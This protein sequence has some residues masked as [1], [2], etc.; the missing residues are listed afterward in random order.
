MERSRDDPKEYKVHLIAPV[1]LT[2]PE[3][4]IKGLTLI[5]E[6]GSSLYL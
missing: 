4:Y 5:G 6:D 2:F 3:A 1:T